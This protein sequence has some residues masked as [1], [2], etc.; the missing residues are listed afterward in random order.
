MMAK[1]RLII[2][3]S[4][5]KLGRALARRRRRHRRARHQSHEPSRSPRRICAGARVHHVPRPRG[6]EDRRPP[7][8]HDHRA[9]GGVARRVRAASRAAP[10]PR[11]SCARPRRAATPV[12]PQSG[13][14]SRRNRGAR[15]RD[16]RRR[17]RAALALRRR[18]AADH[19]R[20]HRCVPRPDATEHGLGAH[21]R[22]RA[23]AISGPRSPRS[24]T[25]TIRATGVCGWWRCSRGRCAS[26]SSSTRPCAP[27]R[28]PK[29]RRDVPAHPL[30]KPASS[31][32]RCGDL[33]AVRARAV[34]AAS[35]RGRPRAE[36][37]EAPGP[38]DRR[39]HGHADVPG[40]RVSPSSRRRRRGLRPS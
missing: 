9:K 34:A 28:R 14:P 24:K 39:G 26:S 30:S 22:R 31:P 32:P 35:G 18:G 6:G 13:R 11:S 36:G 3:R 40:P 21:Q 38:L 10:C 5:E 20:R 23:G 4:L 17:A 7:Q 33:P 29:K 2:V 37:L 15:A 25:S 8:A 16:R 12:D 27:A 19:R 1:R